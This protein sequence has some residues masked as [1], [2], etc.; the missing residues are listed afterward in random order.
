MSSITLDEMTRLSEI[1]VSNWNSPKEKSE[2]WS[3]LSEEFKSEIRQR[4]NL[5]NFQDIPDGGNISTIHNAKN[6]VFVDDEHKERFNK[7]FDRKN[8]EGSGERTLH[9]QRKKLFNENEV[10][11]DSYTGRELK[12]DG[13]TH[14]DHVVS[15]KEIHDN[16]AARLYMRDADRNNMATSSENMAPTDGSLNQS[17]GEHDLLDWMDKEKNGQSNADRFGIDRKKATE[18]HDR[19]SNKI[20]HDVAKAHLA[21]ITNGAK[22]QGIQE[23]KRQVVGILILEFHDIFTNE[24]KLYLKNIRNWKSFSDKVAKFKQ[25]MVRVK[26]NLIQRFRNLKEFISKIFGAAVQGMVSGIV[27]A[28]I[29]AVINTFITTL[30]NVARLIQQSVSSLVQAG[31]VLFVNPD[32]LPMKERIKAFTKILL[33]GILAVLGGFLEEAVKTGLMGMGVPGMLSGWIAG[34]LA[35]L[36]TTLTTAIVVYSI[37]HFGDVIKEL[38]EAIDTIAYGLTHSAR[39][40]Q[41]AFDK[42]MAKIDEMYQNMLLDIREYYSQLNKWSDLAHDLSLAAGEQLSNSITYARMSGVEENRILKNVDEI[43]AFCNS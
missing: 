10:I 19:S 21:E 39:S 22:V 27:G 4:F 34:G 38:K 31:K 11:Y 14:L 42:A 2:F 29:T 7:S 41:E 18:I 3:V 30:K 35:L 1:D 6:N 9:N 40:I 37:D 26:G 32:N 8:Y 33:T 43:D 36:A 24:F 5:S 15:A 13:R 17:K 16:D 25:M 12:K 20:K 28:L 23:A